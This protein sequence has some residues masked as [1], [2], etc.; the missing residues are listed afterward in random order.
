MNTK[1]NGF[2]VAQWITIALV[3]FC[4]VALAGVTL[5]Y[6][7]NFRLPFVDQKYLLEAHSYF[8]FSG[9]VT[10]ALMA[11]MVH[12]LQQ[13]IP[14]L[15]LRVYHLLLLSSCLVS[16]GLFIAFLLQGY[17]ILSI[18]LC[19]TNILIS[20]VFIVRY[21]RDLN[22]IKQEALVS[23]WLRAALVIWVISSLG[24]IALAYLMYNK[25]MIPDFYFGAVYCFLHFQYN[26]WFL[27]ACFALLFS[28]INIQAY[29]S[30]RRGASLFYVMTITVIPT[31][32]LSVLWLKLPP[33]LRW[34]GNIA[35]ILQLLVLI[36]FAGL[37]SGLRK[38]M[39]RNLSV[40]TRRLWSLSAMAFLLKIVLQLFSIL[41]FFSQYAFGYRPIVIGY[42][43]LSFLSIISFFILGYMDIILRKHDRKLP[44]GGVLVF[45]LGVLLQ[46]LI[47]MLQGLEAL[48]VKPLR[49]AP[50]LLFYCA[51]IIAAG[52]IW[53]TVGSRKKQDRM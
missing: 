38:G 27:F 43:H 18:G 9:W 21:W 7:I 41:P 32:V 51:I 40:V 34:T 23:K 17:D 24:A 42:L 12:Y 46:E 4:L 14:A 2:K 6:K 35:G 10:I 39:M 31:F 5:R 1:G 47:L 25:I 30:L 22:K 11:L 26:G 8:A 50:M 13:K 29:G 3:N 48:E 19:S 37:V 33:W 52:L 16:Y 20:Y 28:R 44:S 49:Y 15:N 45:V 53:I 36:Y